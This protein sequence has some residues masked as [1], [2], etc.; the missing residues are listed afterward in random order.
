MANSRTSPALRNDA[1]PKE[2]FETTTQWLNVSSRNSGE[3]FPPSRA[4]IVMNREP[5]FPPAVIPIRGE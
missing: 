2:E 1:V 5:G 4:D 3:V